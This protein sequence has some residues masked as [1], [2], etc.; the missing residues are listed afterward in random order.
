MLSFREDS[1]LRLQIIAFALLIADHIHN[2]SDYEE[3]REEIRLFHEFI[4]Q[5]LVIARASGKLMAVNPSV[6]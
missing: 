3:I 2:E 1:A 4:S 6:N 5:A